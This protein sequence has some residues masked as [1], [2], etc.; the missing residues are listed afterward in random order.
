M[1]GATEGIFQKIL[2]FISSGVRVFASFLFLWLA[3]GMIIG[4]FIAAYKPN[5]ALMIVIGTALSGLLAYYSTAFALIVL[6]LILLI[7]FPL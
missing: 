4:M 5:Y 3:F 7:F 6:I 1:A 2:D